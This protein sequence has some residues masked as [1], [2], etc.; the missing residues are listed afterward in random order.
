MADRRKGRR[1]EKGQG[2]GARGGT[3]NTTQKKHIHIY[4]YIIFQIKKNIHKCI[5]EKEMGGG[6]NASI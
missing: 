1:K 5:K 4:I 6:K 3:L 2:R